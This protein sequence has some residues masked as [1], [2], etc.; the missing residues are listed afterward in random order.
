VTGIGG[1]RLQGLG[2]AVDPMV[3]LVE[4][5]KAAFPDVRNIFYVGAGSYT[6]VRLNEKGEYLGHV[7]N[8]A[9]ASGTGSFLDQQAM[10]LGFPP[11]DLARQAEGAPRCPGVATRCAVFAKT[12]MIHLQQEGYTPKEIA[13]GLCDSLGQA[14]TKMLLKGR[15]LRGGTALCGGVARNRGVRAAVEKTLGFP[16][17]APEK[18]ELSLAMG[19]AVL[20][21]RAGS[22]GPPSPDAV[23]CPETAPGDFHLQP[24]L[25]I[26][27]SS[28]PEFRSHEFRID[29]A[30]TETSLPAPLERGAS[31]R[32]AMGIDIGS[33]STKAVL[34]DERRRVLALGYRATAGNPLRATQLLFQAFRDLEARHG[35][36]FEVIGAGTTGSGRKMMRAVLQ[37]E[38][39][40]DEITAHARAAAFL[41]PAVDTILEIG[42]QDSKFT[43]LENGTVV[44][45][46]MNYVCAAG[47]GSFIEEQA[48]NLGLTVWNY[49]DFVMGSSA[50]LTSDR[51]T[52]FMERDLKE[53]LAEGCSRRE[54][55]AAVLYS[56]RDN[57]MNKVV[58]GLR[59]GRRV[60]FQG[61]TAR[62]KALV[63]AF[64][65]RLGQPILVSEFCHVTGA[66]GIALM[67]LESPPAKRTF[68][69]LPFAQAP[70]ETSSEVCELC[71]NRCALTII[72]TG[73]ETVAWGLKCGRDYADKKPRREGNERAALFESRRRRLL[74]GPASPPES[75]FRVGIP[76]ALT[77]FSHLP[78]WRTFFAELGGEVE[79]SAPSS[80]EVMDAGRGQMTAEFCAPLV[81]ALGHVADLLDKGCSRIFLPCM[82]RGR[83]AENLTDAQFCCFIQ[84]FPSV[85]RT[86]EAVAARPG[87][88]LLSPVIEFGLPPAKAARRLQ[89]SLA[90]AGLSFPLSR[91]RDAWEKGLAAQDAF[92]AKTAVEGAETLRRLE[93]SGELGVAILGRPY[94]VNDPGLNLDLPRKIAALGVTPVPVDALPARP[95][96]LSAEWGNMYWNYGQKVLAAAE[97]VARSK[98]LFGILFTNFACGPDSYLVTYFK[99][100]MGRHHKPYLI[101]QFDGHGA[102]AGYMTRIEAAIESFK[103]FRPR[104]PEPVRLRTEGKLGRDRTV[105]FPP[106]DPYTVH[107]L[108]ACFRG[109][110][111]KSEVLEEN[112][113]TL[114]LGIKHCQGGE[115]V[116]CPSTLGSAI[117]YMET[118]GAKP[119]EVAFFMPTASGPCRFGQYRRLAEI[120]FD[121]RGWEDLLVMSPSAVNAYQGLSGALRRQAWDA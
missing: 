34:M 45:S 115:C 73:G 68:R 96:N 51:C 101:L 7:T 44:N 23:G 97:T 43:Q 19:A 118:T 78:L 100:I 120:V 36:T 24:P 104:P 119:S 88:R 62:N 79:L 26:R 32:V 47:T 2:P 42:G 106:M 35:V 74:E 50:P 41:D 53:R 112:R 107:L 30:G 66:M 37:A 15:K 4:G 72:R 29:E 110:G 21:A 16:V 70:V 90:G 1:E 77:T 39:E 49:A 18:P 92:D 48:K 103:S 85:V 111:Y 84:G 11:E 5:T 54:A 116:P 94:N 99:T 87:V 86:I 17:R 57:Y 40:K 8:T 14:V 98:N 89:E 31:F 102:D 91:V 109:H 56:V 67:L 13:A 10:R 113:S 25:E 59:I 69:G 27:L 108:A 117:H 33:T 61:A 38:L 12:D 3:A 93:A 58:N 63:A 114:D 65:H 9:C 60:Y 64:E 81:M 105:L 6:L 121:H 76:R 82:V 55:A 22:G 52:V 20:A 95:E 71:H 75:Q 28:Y 80:E 83:K 46:V